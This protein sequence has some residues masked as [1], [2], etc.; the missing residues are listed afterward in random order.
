M[1][2]PPDPIAGGRGRV[3]GAV[4]GCLLGQLLQFFLPTLAVRQWPG[5]GAIVGAVSRRKA[6]HKPGGGL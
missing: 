1:K 5:H 6:L 4:F 2:I 3:R